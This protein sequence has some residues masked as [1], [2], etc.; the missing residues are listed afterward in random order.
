L[1]EV[2]E[3]G[4]ATDLDLSITSIKSA[5]E[6]EEAYEIL[7]IFNNTFPLSKKA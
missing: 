6:K 1:D 3:V 4:T 2:N 5:I 7:N